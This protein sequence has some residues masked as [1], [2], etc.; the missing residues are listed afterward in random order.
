MLGRY[1]CIYWSCSD[2][3]NIFPSLLHPLDVHWSCSKKMSLDQEIISVFIYQPSEFCFSGIM[4]H[5]LSRLKVLMETVAIWR[6]V[7]IRGCL[8]YCGSI[9]LIKQI[10]LGRVIRP[11]LRLSGYFEHTAAD[12]GCFSLVWLKHAPLTWALWA[13]LTPWPAT[14]Y[15]LPHEQHLKGFRSPAGKCTFWK[16]LVVESYI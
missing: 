12:L 15:H 7:S 11:P 14:L 2:I 4:F 8:L 5:C 13:D 9:T 16:M 10:S 3:I 1:C 6:K